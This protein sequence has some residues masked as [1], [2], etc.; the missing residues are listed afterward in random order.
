MGSPC[1]RRLEQRACNG[2][3]DR[4]DGL[5]VP[6]GVADTDMRHPLILH[7]R[8]Y[9]GEVKIDQRREIDQIGN[10]LHGL[11]KYLIGFF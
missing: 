7:N 9:I 8:G 6:L 5:V 1:D 2:K 4:L 11:L 3:L 10:S